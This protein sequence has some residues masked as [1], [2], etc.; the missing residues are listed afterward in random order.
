MP[1]FTPM[2]EPWSTITA[3]ALS[4]LLG[5]VPFAL[6]LGRLAGV[7]LRVVGSRNIGAGNLTRQAGL[8]YGIPAA[9]LDGLKGLTP[10]LIARRL[11]LTESVVAACG[12][13]AVVGHNWSIYL[14]GRAGRGLATAV[15]ML[16][17][18]APSLIL[19]TGL[20][21]V[22]GWWIGGGLAGF[23][24]WGLLGPAAFVSARPSVMVGAALTLSMV[25]LIRRMQGN[26]GSPTDLRSRL[27]RAV[28]DTDRVVAEEHSVGERALS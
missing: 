10:V 6:L 23:F 17:G 18:L 22:V 15:G 4:Y 9:L 27:H 1:F 19:W 5:A 20:W 26:P 21:A 28:W 24:G 25:V 14:R 16:A 3:V 7:D 8:R 13:L 2:P 11:G 12:I